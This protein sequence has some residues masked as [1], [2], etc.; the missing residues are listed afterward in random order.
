MT[1][2]WKCFSPLSRLSMSCIRKHLLGEEV[3]SVLDA[4]MPLWMT[5]RP[6]LPKPL[7]ALPMQLGGAISDA[8]SS[9]CLSVLIHFSFK[10]HFPY[11]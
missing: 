2:F 5:S 4:N 7:Q 9:C 10:T 11:I 3:F 1:T 6:L 8:P